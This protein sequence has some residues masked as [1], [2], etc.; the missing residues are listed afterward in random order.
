MTTV[1]TVWLL[2]GLV[3]TALVTI[4]LVALIRQGMLV[5]RTAMRLVREAGTEAEGA[6]S[7][8]RGRAARG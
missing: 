1:A 2:V 7:A 4:L 6:S 3:G 8:R 5:G